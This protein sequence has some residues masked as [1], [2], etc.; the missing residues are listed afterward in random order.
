MSPSE[1]ATLPSTEVRVRRFRAFSPARIAALAGNTF[2]QLLRMKVLYFLALFVVLVFL[3]GFVM[4]AAPS[5]SALTSFGGEQDLRL[6]KAA[7]L[8]GMSMFTVLLSI[9]ATA[10]L[11]PRDLEDRT[12]YTIL[13]K[14]VP[15]FEYLLGK[16][17]GVLLLLGVSLVVMDAVTCGLIY[18]KQSQLLG[19]EIDFL[20]H[21]KWPSQA[22]LDQSIAEVRNIY[23][24]QG[25]QWNF[26]QAVVGIFC[27][28]AVM[29]ALSLLIST[30]SSSTLFTILVGLSFFVIGQGQELARDYLF[31]DLVPVG[32]KAV[33]VVLALLFPDLRQFNV[34]DEIVGGQVIPLSVMLK[35]TGIAALYAAFY[36]IV[37][38]FVFSDKEL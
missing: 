28:A 9:A 4:P 25:L 1:K 37:G 10:L 38:W 8:G 13:C 19:T 12:L 2:T 15:R 22:L 5:T 20:Q 34:V 17:I 16:W 3:L 7:S 11:L 26:Q 21:R 14:P 27:Q 35:M 30:I 18:A 32:Q 29:A 36:Q 23:A 24:A 31:R 6:L 33:S